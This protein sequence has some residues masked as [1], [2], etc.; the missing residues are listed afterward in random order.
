LEVAVLAQQPMLQVEVVGQ[1][2]HF[3]QL[4]QQAVDLVVVGLQSMVGL[5]ALEAALLHTEVLLQQVALVLL[6]KATTVVMALLQQVVAGVV[7]AQ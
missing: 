7:L 5:E 4:H 1:I 6:D 2:A 3:Q